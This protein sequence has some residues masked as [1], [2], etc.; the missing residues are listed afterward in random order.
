M[1]FSP[2]CGLL[3]N[4]C[5]DTKEEFLENFDTFIKTIGEANLKRDA[6]EW[7]AHD[8]KFERLIKECYQLHEEE[9]GTFKK[10][11]FWT[12]AGKYYMYRHGGE[13]VK[14]LLD[15]DNPISKL[16]LENLDIIPG[17]GTVAAIYNIVKGLSKSDND[18][19]K[20]AK[21]SIDL[22]TLKDLFK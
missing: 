13:A 18:M 17:L 20:E 4:P 12:D 21:A 5:G 15:K 6:P 10:A 1:L 22:S 2:S 19:A 9:L 11:E 7:T 14:V 16:I 3:E 8:A